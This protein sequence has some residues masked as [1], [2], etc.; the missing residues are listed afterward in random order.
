MNKRGKANVDLR[1][2]LPRIRHEVSHTGTSWTGAGPVE[3]L[4]GTQAIRLLR[5]EILVD[6][7]VHKPA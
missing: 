3:G 2:L 5:F 6:G 1:L 7:F 4:G